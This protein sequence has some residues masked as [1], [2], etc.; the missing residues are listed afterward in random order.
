VLG[1]FLP[2]GSLAFFTYKHEEDYTKKREA[3]SIKAK[4]FRH[5]IGKLKIQIL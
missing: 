2:L 3:L 4:I 1:I 5:Y